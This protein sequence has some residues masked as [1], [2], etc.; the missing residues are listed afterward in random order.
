MLVNAVK[1]IFFENT[2]LPQLVVFP[3]E[4]NILQTTIITKY[5]NFYNC[6]NKNEKRVFEHRVFRF[7][8]EH[9]FI[10]NGIKI[11]E[12]IKTLVATMA[13]TLTF[14]MRRYLF[15]RVNTIIIYPKSYYST[16]LD[17][18]HKGETN[19]KLH[20]VV[21]SWLD[22]LEGINDK[23]DNLNL[24]LHEFSHALHFGFLNEQSYSAYNFKKYFDQILLFLINP[25][26]QKQLLNTNYL[27]SYAF[28]NKFE[29]LAVL[30]EHFFET[31]TEFKQKLPE[32]FLL[33]QKMLN[34][35][36]LKIYKNKPVI[37]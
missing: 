8:D 12:E 14:G 4:L 2:N 20:L 1:G 13:I 28:E 35:D 5:S 18:Y 34:I 17:Q 7:I 6:L 27:R 32:V 21:F 3:K 30:I 9:K 33:V 36:I 29:F 26:N 19:P 22:F 25:E 24:A 31:P 11:T 15:S 23:Q 37:N 10:G 16:I